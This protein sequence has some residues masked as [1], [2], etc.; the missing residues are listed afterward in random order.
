LRSPEPWLSLSSLDLMRGEYAI[1]A[2]FLI[3]IAAIG[4]WL[5]VLPWTAKYRRSSRWLRDVAI[6]GGIAALLSSSGHS[7]LLFYGHALDRARFLEV[8]VVSYLASGM[9]MGLLLSLVFSAEFWEPRGPSHWKT[10]ML[11]S[12]KV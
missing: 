1:A 5:I 6:A 10:H 9:W 2:S 11:R 3:A 12:R 7:V 4:V 8:N